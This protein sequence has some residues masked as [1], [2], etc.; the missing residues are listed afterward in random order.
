MT[1][2]I[3]DYIFTFILSTDSFICNQFCFWGIHCSTFLEHYAIYREGLNGRK[4]KVRVRTSTGCSPSE[5]VKYLIKN[6]GEDQEDKE[7]AHSALLGKS[8]VKKKEWVCSL[9][10]LTLHHNSQCKLLFVLLSASAD[11]F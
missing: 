10:Y 3:T 8:E 6:N 7:F 4:H 11:H 5:S 1:Q 9:A 2:A